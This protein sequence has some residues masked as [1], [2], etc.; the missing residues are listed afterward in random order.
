MK[1]VFRKNIGIPD[2]HARRTYR[3]SQAGPGRLG[4]TAVRQKVQ[5]MQTTLVLLACFWTT[6]L[7]MILTIEIDDVCKF[8]QVHSQSNSDIPQG[9]KASQTG[10]SHSHQDGDF[11]PLEDS[12]VDESHYWALD[13]TQVRR[14]ASYWLPA[15]P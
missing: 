8:Q 12:T 5:D 7:H 2:C 6:S 3:P 4:R 9:Q 11:V 1:G 15:L 14:R 10:E 13:G